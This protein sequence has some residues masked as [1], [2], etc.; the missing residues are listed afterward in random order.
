MSEQTTKKTTKKTAPKTA[1][2]TRKTAQSEKKP[3]TAANAAHV[4]E[5]I[6]AAAN[7]A[8]DMPDGN[9]AGVDE[10]NAVERDNAEGNAPENTAPGAGGNAETPDN[11]ADQSGGNPDGNA[12]EAGGDPNAAAP[13]AEG[14]DTEGEA[15]A[16]AW[17]VARMLKVTKPLMQGDD[18]K[19]LQAALIAHGYHCGVNGANGVYGRETAY[20]VRCFQSANRLIVDGRAGRYT[21]AALGGVWEG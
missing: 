11:G 9:T 6:T 8:P 14:E 13:A 17:K 2:R 1:T 21:V 12:P 18:V 5:E 4:S 10:G 7:T 15:D 3:K 16:G 20:A 19:A